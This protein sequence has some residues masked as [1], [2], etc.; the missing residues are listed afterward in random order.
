MMGYRFKS[1]GWNRTLNIPPLQHTTPL[2]TTPHLNPLQDA[3]HS[4]LLPSFRPVFHRC[5]F[6]DAPGCLRLI[7]V[8]VG[9]EGCIARGFGNHCLRG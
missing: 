1:L 4:P 3:Y 7:L 5:V 8:V 9:E 2:F 6:V